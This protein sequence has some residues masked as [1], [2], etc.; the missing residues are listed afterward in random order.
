MP[1]LNEQTARKLIE[2]DLSGNYVDAAEFFSPN[3]KKPCVSID[4]WFSL[5]VLE[6]IVWWLK[7]KPGVPLP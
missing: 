7:N 1:E 2:T 4:G 5:E 3:V 6:A